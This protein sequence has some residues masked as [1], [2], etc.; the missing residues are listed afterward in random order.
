MRSTLKWSAPLA[1][2]VVIGIAGPANAQAQDF[3][4]NV[5]KGRKTLTDLIT[6]LDSIETRNKAARAAAMSG[7]GTRTVAAAPGKSRT[8]TLILTGAQ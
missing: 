2:L 6:L 8:Y 4:T 5:E 1:A 3:Q 7:E